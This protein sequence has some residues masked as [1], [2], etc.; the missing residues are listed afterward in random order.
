MR[1]AR[2]G[3]PAATVPVT[4]PTSYSTTFSTNEAIL[5]EGGVWLTGAATAIDWT[6]PTV[7]GGLCYGTQSPSSTAF[8]D[9]VFVLN[10]AKYNIGPNQYASAVIRR[11]GV[12]LSGSKEC[13]LLLRAQLSAHSMTA[14]EINLN[15]DGGYLQVI[16]VGGVTGGAIGTTLGDFPNNNFGSVGFS[17]ADGDFFE[18][19]IIGSLV[20]VWLTHASTRTQYVTNFDVTTLSGTYHATGSIGGGYYLVANDYC[21]TSW[22]GNTLP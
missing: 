9:S 15:F 18:A 7:A 13:E 20:S 22:S 5:S 4:L 14:Y 11:S 10:P 21:F 2:S 17:I 19:Q 3:K 12:G 1:T 8:D 16:N 6:D